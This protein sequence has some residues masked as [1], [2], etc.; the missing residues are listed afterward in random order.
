[1][2]LSFID[3]DWRILLC[4]YIFGF[5]YVASVWYMVSEWRQVTTTRHCSCKHAVIETFSKVVLKS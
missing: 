5:G 3:S 2:E 1:M 4:F